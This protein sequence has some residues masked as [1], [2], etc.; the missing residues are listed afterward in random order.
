V[1]LLDDVISELDAPHRSQLLAA[2][3]QAQ[4]VVMTTTDLLHYSREFLSAATLWRVS[5]GRIVNGYR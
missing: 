1:L 5:A 4:Q 3:D 2:I